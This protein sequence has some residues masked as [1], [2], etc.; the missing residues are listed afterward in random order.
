MAP[1]NVKLVISGAFEIVGILGFL[2]CI[3]LYSPLLA[4]AIGSLFL[5]LVG[6]IID[7]PLRK[8]GKAE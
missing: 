4:G 5:I 8:K 2:G 7:P 6:N 1:I 3:F